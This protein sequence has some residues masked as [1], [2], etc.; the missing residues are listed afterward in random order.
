[1]SLMVLAARARTVRTAS[2]ID[3]SACPESR[4]VFVIDDIASS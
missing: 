4:M 2:S 1:M 3:P